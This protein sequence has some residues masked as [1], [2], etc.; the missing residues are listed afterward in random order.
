MSTFGAHGNARNGPVQRRRCY[1]CNVQ[2]LPT[3]PMHH[4]CPECWREHAS[5]AYQR[6]AA[7]MDASD[8][9]EELE[10]GYLAGVTHAANVDSD[11]S[12]SED[13][14]HPYPT[15]RQRLQTS[16][17]VFTSSSDLTETEEEDEDEEVPDV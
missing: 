9:M 15:K 12:P 17:D 14:V 8:E 13:D 16:A 11:S 10:D 2:F 5:Q 4:Y 3:H 7:R 1:G 6:N